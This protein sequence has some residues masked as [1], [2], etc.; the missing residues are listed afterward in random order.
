MLLHRR[1]PRFLT[2]LSIICFETF[3]QARFMDRPGNN[4]TQLGRDNGY[5]RVNVKRSLA[6]ELR[7]ISGKSACVF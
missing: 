7:A 1:R 4:A 6:T 3:G 2:K 5:I